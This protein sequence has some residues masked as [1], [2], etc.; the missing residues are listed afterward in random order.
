L[1]IS[2]ASRNFSPTNALNEIWSGVHQ[3]KTI[4]SLTDELSYEKLEAYSVQLGQIATTLFCPSNMKMALISEQDSLKHGTGL[5][6]QIRSS[7]LQ[8]GVENFSV[9]PL[10][11]ARNLPWEGWST[12]TAVSFVAQTFKGV[13]MNHPDAPCLSVLSKI[14]RSLYLHRELR[15]KGGAYGGFALYNPEDGLFS[16]GSYRDPH[17]INTLK[18]YE[19]AAA[20]ISADNFTDEDVKEA[21]LQVC[22]EIDKPD[23]PGPA[24]RKAY[25]RSLIKLTDKERLSFKEKLLTLRKDE[26]IA[27]AKRYFNV[28]NIPKAVAVI[29]NQDKLK[30]ANQSLS[31]H[32]LSLQPI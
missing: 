4:K 11:V 6:E 3:L 28:D 8:D 14:L 18:V 25:F 24:A 15:E 27:V 20:F 32:P 17:I 22:S 16:F 7:F 2:L 19:Q 12:A 5:V 21:V 9:P 26:V 30:Q 13:R 31:D 29:S 23:P 10:K 1:A